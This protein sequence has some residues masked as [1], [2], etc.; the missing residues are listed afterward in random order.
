[1]IKEISSP[2]LKN[3]IFIAAWPGMGEVAYRAAIF[4]KEALG[5]KLFAK[6]EA[7]RFFKPT[8]VF[9]DKGVINM[10]TAPAGFFYY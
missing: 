8:A 1:M 9:V 10:P 2:K 6:L 3:P 7:H 5:F 4:L